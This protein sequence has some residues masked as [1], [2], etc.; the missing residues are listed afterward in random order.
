[1]KLNETAPVKEPLTKPK[2]VPTRK[3]DPFSPPKPKV[4]PTPKGKKIR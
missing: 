4:D 2:T 3:K 1:V